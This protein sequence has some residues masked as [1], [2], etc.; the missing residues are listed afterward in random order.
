MVSARSAMLFTSLT[1]AV[2]FLSLLLTPIPPVQV[3]GTFVAFGILLAFALTILLIPAYVVR[4]RPTAL[5]ALAAR[6]K[7]PHTETPLARALR[8]VGRFAFRRGKLIT[9]AAVLVIALSVA[10]IYQIQI[11]DN[12]VKFL[13]SFRKC[14]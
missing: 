11:N 10:G 14:T 6:S 12:P 4:M 2:G 3:F 1:S 9:G 7:T 8:S 5:A 13:K